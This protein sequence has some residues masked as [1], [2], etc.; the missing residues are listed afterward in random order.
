MKT[1]F[2]SFQSSV[3]GQE[4]RVRRSA[5]TLIELILV[6]GIVA[7]SSVVILPNFLASRQKRSLEGAAGIMVAQLNYTQQRSRSQ[8]DGKQWWLHIHNPAGA[9]N[10]YYTICAGT[11]YSGT[12]GANCA[13]EGGSE[14]SR[15]T[16]SPEVSLTDPSEGGQKVIAFAKSTGTV[17]SQAL[18]VF[19]AGSLTKTIT[20]ETSGKVTA[21]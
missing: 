17:S 8:E 12:M 11:D 9:G 15:I 18:I 21:N 20:V 2:G 10:D 16:I 14:I 1:N 19:S 5:F 6:I 7:L 4:S 13:A 3:K